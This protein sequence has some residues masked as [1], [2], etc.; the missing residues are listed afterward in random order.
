MT[1]LVAGASS[2]AAQHCAACIDCKC[3]SQRLSE[4]SDEAR[5]KPCDID[6][7]DRSQPSDRQ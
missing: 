7:L 1:A 4:K 5:R 3:V 2:N 6:Y